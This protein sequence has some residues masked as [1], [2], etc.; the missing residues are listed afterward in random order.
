M[1]LTA[2]L[3]TLGAGALKSREDPKILGT[4]KESSLLQ[5]ASAFYK[6]F[7]IECSR[8][9]VSVDMFLFGSGYMDVATLGEYQR[10]LSF[11]VLKQKGKHAFP[12]T[13]L[14]RHTST[15]PSTHG[16]GK[17]RPSLRASSARYWRC[18]L[19]SRQL[20]GCA[21]V[22]VRLL[23]TA[24][25]IVTHRHPMLHFTSPYLDVYSNYARLLNP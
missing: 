9:Q 14:V 24:G 1:T 4:S 13:L 21:Q 18:Q 5:P 3:P 8:S 11:R 16:L 7:A 15:L 17:T 25:F 10:G 19:C 20:Y 23:S 2:S 22:E 12:I 6:T